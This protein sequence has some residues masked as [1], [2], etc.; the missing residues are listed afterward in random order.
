MCWVHHG[1]EPLVLMQ[2]LFSIIVAR[3]GARLFSCV[4]LVLFSCLGGLS[5]R[6]GGVFSR[7]A[8]TDLFPVPWLFVYLN[9]Y[10]SACKVGFETVS[11]G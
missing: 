9:A 10:L 5:S 4:G 11:Y 7:L 6:L 3:L 8:S 2:Q 1:D